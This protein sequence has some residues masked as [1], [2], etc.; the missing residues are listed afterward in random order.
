MAEYACQ[1][2]LLDLYIKLS[3]LKTEIFKAGVLYDRRRFHL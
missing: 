1:Q 2:T 3:V